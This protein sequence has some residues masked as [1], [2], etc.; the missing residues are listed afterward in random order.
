[1]IHVITS[2]N[3]H[4]YQQELLA[5]HRLRHEIYVVE[6]KWENLARPDYLERDEFDGEAASY[7]L[8]IDDERVVGGSRLIPTTEPHLLSEVF[9]YLAA[10]RGLPRGREI[11]EWT[12]M[13]VIKERREGRN[14]G[15]TAGTVI[16]GVLEH[17]LDLGVTDLT[18]LVEMWWLPRF[19]DM[20]WK[21]RPLG[22][23][24]LISGEWSVAVQMPIDSRTLESTRTFH[25]ITGS[26]LAV[27]RSTE[28]HVIAA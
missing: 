18:A 16:C 1:M 6:R 5:H 4:L 11:Y 8:A 25:N 3:R 2:A 7:I 17:C 26:V 27:S 13:F 9:P 19:H 23:P 24:E 12:R 21:L 15:R 10:V 20:G 14:M 28:T 22:L